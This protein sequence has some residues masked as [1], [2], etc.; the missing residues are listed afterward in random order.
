M[1]RV[2]DAANA[3]VNAVLE[4]CAIYNVGVIRQQSRVFTVATGGRTRPMYVGD[5]VD[6]FGIRHTCGMCDVLAWPRINIVRA[7]PRGPSIVPM[8][9]RVDVLPD[10]NAAFV[11]VPLWVE[12]KSGGGSL[13][14]EQKD[15]RDWVERTGAFH[16][17]CTDSADSLIE[18]F[19]KMGVQR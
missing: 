13:T 1:G 18:W 12:C 16:L 14:K 5:W 2:V 8:N 17:L 15:F 10:V 7:I 11:T 19:G 6:D 3:V 4:T 9:S